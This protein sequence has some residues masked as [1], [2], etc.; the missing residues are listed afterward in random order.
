MNMEAM[1]ENKTISD[2][3]HMHVVVSRKLL[4]F[5]LNEATF[6]E[7]YRARINNLFEL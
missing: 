4:S 2:A 5:T 7:Q 1:S 3:M 6:M